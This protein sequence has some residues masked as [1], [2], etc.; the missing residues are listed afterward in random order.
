MTMS[1]SNSHAPATLGKDDYE[2]LSRFR[3][4]L[5]RFLRI[6]ERICQTHGL[7]PLQYQLLLHVQG[8]PAG[9]GPASANWPSACRR[10]TM[11]WWPWSTVA[12]SWVWWNAAPDAW[13]GGWWRSICCLRERR[14]WNASLPCTRTSC[15]N[16]SGSS[17]GWAI[18]STRIPRIA[19]P[20]SAPRFSKTQRPK[21]QLPLCWHDKHCT[22][23][24]MC[25]KPAAAS[26]RQAH[27]LP[28]RPSRPNTGVTIRPSWRAV[29][30]AQS[31]NVTTPWPRGPVLSTG[32]W[33]PRCA[34]APAPYRQAKGSG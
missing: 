7:T 24:C 31:G 16:C 34:P 32:W 1:S 5:R 28:F 19:K 14:S 4:R 3:H 11:A 13:T 21:S 12:E 18:R 20:W 27:R 30:Q 9:I 25:G 26:C 10:S 2:R 33:I 23:P 29:S 22:N 8:Y 6:S 15:N 17:P